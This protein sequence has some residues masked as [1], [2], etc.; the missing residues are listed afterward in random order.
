MEGT[1]IFI[2]FHD[3]KVAGVRQHEIAVAV[4]QYTAEEGI[5]IDM[6]LLEEVSRHG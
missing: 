4:L 5:A 6:R 1:V 2:G 3:A